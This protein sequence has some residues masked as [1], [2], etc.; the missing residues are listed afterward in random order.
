MQEGFGYKYGKSGA[1]SA[2]SM[3]IAEL[4]QL[5]E[6]HPQG[7][8]VSTIK[9]DILEFNVLHKPTA[10]SRKLTFRHLQDLYALDPSVCLY[11][12]L[13]HLWER[14]N[15]STRAILA[16]QLAYCRDPLLRVVL[17]LLTE[18]KPGEPVSREQT[19]AL[20]EQHNPGAYSPASL[21]SFA[22]NLNGS[23]T[24]AGFLQGRSKKVR[25]QPTIG[26][27]NVAYALFI[28]YLNQQEGTLALRSEWILLLGLND[29]EI[30]GLAQGA[31][32]RGLIKFTN[33][34][35]VMEIRFPDWLTEAEKELL[36]G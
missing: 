19:E 17:P 8:S 4:S 9:S 14:S 6:Q 27:A 2:R 7:A 16:F 25:C 35:D 26:A 3:M 32:S 33:A 24:Q 22:Q 18:L 13:L 12:N 36:D 21:K 34:S 5:L 20:I 28:A 1:H 30:L 10:N 15:E 11:R 31:H 23:L 29:D